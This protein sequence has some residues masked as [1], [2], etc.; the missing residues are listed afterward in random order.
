MNRPK[1]I[2]LVGVPG[3]G[4]TTYAKAYINSNSNTI[5]LSSD[6]IRAELYGDE[7]IQ[8]NPAEVFSLMQKRAIE[9][10]NEGQDVIYDATNITRKDRSSIIGICPK[11]AKI[12][13]HIIWA[14][15]EVCIERDTARERTVGKAVID[16]MLKRFQA[17]YYDEGIDK[18]VIVRP[19]FWDWDG[20]NYAEECFAD[21][22]I[23]HDN[24]H[25]TLDII[26]HCW[27]AER[28]LFNKD[29][30]DED[31]LFA[32]LRH[33]IG[34]PYVKAFIDSKGNPCEQAHYYQHQCVGAWMSYG[35]GSIT[36]HSAW[37]I[38][39]HM[40]PFLNTKYYKNL[41]AFLKKDI[42]LLHEADLAAH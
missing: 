6:L 9:A 38:S 35:F 23:P 25:H 19:D 32:T 40:D 41:P 36:P 10:L 30:I 42:D 22:R 17:P 29:I 5:H 16:K 39:I 37:L 7:S 28:Y 34:K 31:L 24:P 2:L 27:E 13:A 11:F 20:H 8:G 3:S 15:I 14:P 4:K 21:M 12:E 33:D 26:D 1:L 18:I